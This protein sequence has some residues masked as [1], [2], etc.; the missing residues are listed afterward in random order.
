MKHLVRLFGP[1]RDAAGSA[2]I[3]TEAAA[4]VAELLAA[5]AER[6]PAL[7][8]MLAVSAVAVNRE[9]APPERGLAPDDEIA[10]IPPVSGG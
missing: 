7:R 9:Y 3:E 5:V 1:A 10:L 4:T 6:Y 8:E 2:Q